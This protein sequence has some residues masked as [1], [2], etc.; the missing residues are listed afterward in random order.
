MLNDCTPAE[1]ERLPDTGVGEDWERILS[2]VF[3]TS[4]IY[5][6]RSSTLIFIDADNH[7][8]FVEKTYA[9]ERENDEKTVRFEFDIER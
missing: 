1:T 5:G 6:T 8:T 7:V 2:P 4:A 9:K 3:I